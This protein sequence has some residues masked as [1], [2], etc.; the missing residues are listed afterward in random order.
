M[1]PRH[2][3]GPVRSKQHQYHQQKHQDDIGATL[4][5]MESD[6]R[7]HHGEANYFVPLSRTQSQQCRPYVQEGSGGG[8][9][10]K[11]TTTA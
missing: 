4:I 7:V 11:T 5:V 8:R 9:V 6:T 3:C 2:Y 10:P 1:Q